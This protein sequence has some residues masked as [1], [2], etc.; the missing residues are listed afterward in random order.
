MGDE[1]VTTGEASPRRLYLMQVAS[2][3]VPT[4]A[5]PL[6]W[7]VV[8]YLIQMSE[9]T[10]VL[11]DSGLPADFEH[12]GAQPVT[13]GPDVIAQLAALGLRPTDIAY[14]VCTHFDVDHAGHHDAFTKAE[15]IVQREHYDLARGGHPRSAAARAYWDH[16]DLRYRTIDGDT[17]LLPGLTLLAT[18]GHAPGHQSVL[19]R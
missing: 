2:G 17:E 12:P 15:L 6:L 7:P 8:C 19:V 16:P 9:G 1:L 13:R 4:P 11:V 14:L 18:G 3:T 5:G 10:N